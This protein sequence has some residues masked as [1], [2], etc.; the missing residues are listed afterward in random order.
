MV[1]ESFLIAFRA[2]VPFIIY[3][4][5]GAGSV[6]FRLTD[7]AFLNRMNSFVFKIMFPC[8]MFRNIYYT[9]A[10][11]VP[12]M[13]Y[14]LFCIFSIVGLI[15]V[16]ML[17]VPRIIPENPRRGV[18]VQA[19][20]RGNVALF[21]MP[22]AGY[23]YGDRSAPLAAVVLSVV[24]TIFN[25]SA[26]IVLE[27]FR[28][29]SVSPRKLLRNVVTNPLLIGVA[30]GFVFRL[31]RIPVPDF[32]GDPVKTLGSMATPLALIALGGTLEIT[33]FRENRRVLAGVTVVKMVIIPIL[34]Y[35]IMLLLPYTNMERFVLLLIF[36]TPTA[37]S[38][39]PMAQNMGG[40][41]P[42]AGQLVAVTTLV[43]VVTMF[44]FIFGLNMLGRLY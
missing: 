28:G 39:Y 41:G 18:V 23:I 9:D 1:F 17:T 27:Y 35:G 34:M 37:V 2:V 25:V 38:S 21:A 14:V 13:R 33:S 42:L 26:I 29:G 8:L 11:M 36:A 3:M 12:D 32:L 24:V 30:T 20:Y 22:L 6:R 19:I 44:L 16:L 7:R 43:S 40:D 4:L 5:V 31:A 15:V 10:E